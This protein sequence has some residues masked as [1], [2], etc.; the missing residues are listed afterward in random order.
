MTLNKN[1][2]RELGLVEHGLESIDRCDKRENTLSK[3]DI[4]TPELVYDKVC[5][6]DH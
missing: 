6:V 5:I 1:S 2:C 4:P 3:H